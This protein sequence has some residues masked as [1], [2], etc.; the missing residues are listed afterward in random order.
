MRRTYQAAGASPLCG[1]IVTSAMWDE[2]DA[3]LG[4]ASVRRERTPR[5]AAAMVERYGSATVPPR[6]RSTTSRGD[7]RLDRVLTTTQRLHQASSRRSG[8]ALA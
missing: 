3:V 5:G 8:P 6:R 2:L 1:V 7:H 4:G